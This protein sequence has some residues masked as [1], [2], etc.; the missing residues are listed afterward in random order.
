MERIGI[1]GGG[2]LGKMIAIAAYNLGFR[3]CVFAE[4]D[5]SPAVNLSSDYIIAPLSDKSA[6]FHFAESVDFITFETENIPSST[7]DL[8][9]EKFN[10]PNVKAIK[11]AQNRLLEK[12]FLKKYGISTT[13]YW[14]IYK[15]EDL[16]KV[17]FPVLLKTVRG[18][19]DGKGQVLVKS[20]DQIRDRTTD[21]EFP[22]IAEK[23]FDIYREFSIVISRNKTGKVYFPIAENV[24]V[25]GVLKTSKVPSD[26][27]EEI[28]NDIKRIS[29]EIADLLQINGLI[30]VE[31]FL[32]KKGSLVVN[33]IAPRPHNSCH[34][35]MDCC[36]ID[37]FEELILSI[38]GSKLKQPNLICPCTM[39]N[40]LGDEITT[41]KDLILKK[42]VRLYNYGKEYHKHLR[43]M[44]HINI[45][46]P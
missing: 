18:G 35:S 5:N 13:Q 44:G 39:K 26:A 10:T 11:I 9:E 38:T 8:L 1:I 42:N 19:Y 32:D 36:D 17:D 29:F 4:E 30:C 45:L 25:N 31:F 46:F 24:H 3:V 43:K 14:H 21:L 2:Q 7:L 22:L 40:V 33:E 28:E 15:Q 41:W 34:W 23:I 20:Y 37:Q 12:D 6:I 27:P 16:K